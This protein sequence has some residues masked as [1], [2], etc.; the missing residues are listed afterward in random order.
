MD[1]KGWDGMG[2]DG[3]GGGVVARVRWDGI[4][5]SRGGEG[6]DGVGGRGGTPRDGR[7]DGTVSIPPE[8]KEQQHGIKQQQEQQQ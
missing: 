7:Q 8:Q 4:H 3:M 5:P 6:R 1:G 2:R